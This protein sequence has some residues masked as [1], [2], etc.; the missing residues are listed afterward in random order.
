MIIKKS[1]E[2]GSE[3]TMQHVVAA[4]DIHEPNE[5]DPLC[6]PK[7]SS[8]MKIL[9]FIEDPEVIK[10]ILKH[11][12]LWH[13]KV[14]PPPRANAPPT[15]VHIDYSDSQVPPSGDYLFHDT[16]YPIESYAS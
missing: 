6:C 14:R 11:M 9:S 5:T 8:K 12:G 2:R 13:V 4:S 1:I 15:D 10:K 16:D 7:C 3:E